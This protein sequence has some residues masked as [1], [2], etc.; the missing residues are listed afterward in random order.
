[1]TFEPI[2]VYRG[3]KVTFGYH[4]TRGREPTAFPSHVNDRTYMY[5]LNIWKEGRGMLMISAHDFHVP[6]CHV[7]DIIT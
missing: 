5:A 3:T 7:Y 6:Y 1:M 2:Y 4:C